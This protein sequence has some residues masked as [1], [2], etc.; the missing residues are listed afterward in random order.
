MVE[1]IDLEIL[2]LQKSPLSPSISLPSSLCFL[3]PLESTVVDK[4]FSWLII[5]LW[6]HLFPTLSSFSLSII[7]LT[8]W[9]SGYA[10]PD[11]TSQNTPSP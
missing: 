1:L 7:D 3:L 2:V 8:Q 6:N 5:F 9:L 4:S 11:M 10:Q